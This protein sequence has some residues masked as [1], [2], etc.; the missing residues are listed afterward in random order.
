MFE[1]GKMPKELKGNHLKQKLNDYLTKNL[2][3]KYVLNIKNMKNE[4]DC[5]KLLQ[6]YLKQLTEDL[7]LPKDMFKINLVS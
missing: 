7:I 5:L 4:S 1:N 2:D 6:D 3:K